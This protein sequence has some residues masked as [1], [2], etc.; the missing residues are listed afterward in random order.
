MTASIALKSFIHGELSDWKYSEIF[1]T[2]SVLIGVIALTVISGDDNLIGLTS[3]VTG[4]LYTL[5][6]GKGKTSCYFFGLINTILYGAISW[7]NRIYGDA[8]LNW[9]YY[10][11]MQIAGMILWLRNRVPGKGTIIKKRMKRK[12]WLA[13]GTATVI[14]WLGLAAVL[15][16]S[17]YER[18]CSLTGSF[19]T[20]NA[21]ALAALPLPDRETLLAI[22]R[23]LSVGRNYS[24][25]V[26]DVVATA[27]L[28]R[29]LRL[30]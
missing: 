2:V 24:L 23:R 28:S 27:A 6:A 1:F 17:Y 19:A 22:G 7:N 8:F 15:S 30:D 16:C 18:Y 3:A 20:V 26:T 11:P 14:F 29:I 13:G 5:L 21:A 4:I 25:R 10:F 9:G 12:E